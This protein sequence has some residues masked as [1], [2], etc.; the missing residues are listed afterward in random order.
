MSVRPPV[1]GPTRGSG[2]R[3]VVSRR[4]IFVGLILGCVVVLALASRVQLRTTGTAEYADPGWD[5][6]LYIAMA[7]SGPFDFGLAPYNRRVLVPAVARMLPGSLQSGFAATTLGFAIIAAG[8]VYLLA[9]A[10]GHSGFVSLLGV[11]LV[12]S[13]SWGLKYSI[14]DFWIPDAAVLAFVTMAFFFA[15]RRQSVPF[16]VCS[17]ARS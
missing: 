6:H 9:R 16:A 8:A 12:A 7:D 15:V 10:R 17:R 11:L 4:D 1:R 5:R 13:L 14:A 2:V 3:D